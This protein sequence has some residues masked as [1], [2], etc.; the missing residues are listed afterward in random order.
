[1][2]KGEREMS[3]ILRCDGRKCEGKRFWTGYFIV[4]IQKYEPGI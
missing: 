1:M 4:L 2:R 3:H